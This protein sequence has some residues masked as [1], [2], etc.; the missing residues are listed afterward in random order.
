MTRVKVCGL[1]RREGVEA[2]LDAGADALGFVFEPTSPRA[3]ASPELPVSLGPFVTCVAVFGPYRVVQTGC[4]VVQCV[5]GEPDGP[6][7]RAWR[8]GP[9]DT[10]D[11]VRAAVLEGRCPDAVLLDARH[12]MAFGGTGTVV[13]WGLAGEIVAALPVPVIL[14]GGLH[15]ANVAEA[16]RRVRPYAV[17]ASSGLETSPGIKDPERIRAFIGNAKS[18]GG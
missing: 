2:A 6:W 14:A 16:V 10:P 15:P 3:I 1:T 8:L 7:I 17:D 5:S 11:A 4:G 12:P 13:D 18:A 9:A